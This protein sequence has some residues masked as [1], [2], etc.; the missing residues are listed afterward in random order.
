MESSTGD[1]K[2]SRKERAALAPTSGAQEQAAAGAPAPVRDAGP[3]EMRD[4]DGS[5]WDEV[6]EGSDESFPAS[7]PPSFTAPKHD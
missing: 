5:D 7:D 2:P 1:D 6:D 3:A 4:E